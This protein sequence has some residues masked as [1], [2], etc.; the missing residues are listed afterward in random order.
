MI[1][2]ELWRNSVIK[3]LMSA[4]RNLGYVDN[5]L[6]FSKLENRHFALN[7]LLVRVR[8]NRM[9]TRAFALEKSI[10]LQCGI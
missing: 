8:L 9:I 5:S 3:W 1:S 6:A 2:L 10:L 4:Y 7:F